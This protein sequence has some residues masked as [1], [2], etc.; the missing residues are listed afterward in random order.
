MQTT[1]ANQI[2]RWKRSTSS[3]KRSEVADGSARAARCWSTAEAANAAAAPRASNADAG[4]FTVI[5]PG[6]FIVAPPVG[7]SLPRVGAATST[8]RTEP[9]HDG[10]GSTARGPAP[11]A[12]AGGGSRR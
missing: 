9:A 6:R 12:G 10:D 5:E 1:P 2:G 11:E 3:R 8:G 4:R 7:S